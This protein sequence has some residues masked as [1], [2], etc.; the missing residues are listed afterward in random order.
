MYIIQCY[1]NICYF[2]AET[3]NL[4]MISMSGDST[5]Y[6]SPIAGVLTPLYLI[7]KKKSNNNN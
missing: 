3:K 6:C 2:L 5:K 4:A 1:S 7:F